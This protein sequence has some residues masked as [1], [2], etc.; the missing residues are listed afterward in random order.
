MTKAV[1]KKLKQDAGVDFPHELMYL[2]RKGRQH[3]FITYKEILQSHPQIEDDLETIDDFLR[4]VASIGVELK[5]ARPLLEI[6]EEVTPT[7]GKKKTGREDETASISDDSV[8]MY[9]REIGQYQLLTSAE[10]V[11]LAKRIEQGDRSA[12][13]R[14]A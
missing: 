4:Y 5:E 13:R 1:P 10:E 6:P 2:V 12:K 14:L 8:R 9:L 11:A 7:T 3:G